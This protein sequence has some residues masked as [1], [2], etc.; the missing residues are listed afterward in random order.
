MIC[1]IAS[2]FEA[3]KSLL[4]PLWNGGCQSTFAGNNA[5]LPPHVLDFAILH[6]QRFWRETLSFLDF[7]WP[8][9][10]QWEPEL[11]GKNFQLY[12]NYDY[13][14]PSWLEDIST[15]V[16]HRK[17]EGKESLLIDWLIDWLIDM[18][19]NMHVLIIRGYGS[20][21]PRERIQDLYP[22]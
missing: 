18:F 5:L 3:G 15:W 16:L 2:N 13:D 21:K 4:K 11:L 22:L 10:N 19:S 20:K 12:S 7:M 9:R 14:L 6:A 8:R 1:Y 17:F